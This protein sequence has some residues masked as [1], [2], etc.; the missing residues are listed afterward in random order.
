MSFIVTNSAVQYHSNVGLSV[1]SSIV[2]QS[3]YVVDKNVRLAETG[4]AYVIIK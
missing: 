3:C 4:L 2:L 1:L